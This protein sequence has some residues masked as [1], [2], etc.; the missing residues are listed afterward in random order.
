MILTPVR[1]IQFEILGYLATI[2][3]HVFYKFD[4]GINHCFSVG[5]SDQSGE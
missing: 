4:E 1:N 3:F 5:S 2:L